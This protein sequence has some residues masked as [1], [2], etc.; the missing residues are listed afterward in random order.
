[1][2]ISGIASPV[3]GKAPA[4]NEGH[5]YNERNGRRNEMTENHLSSGNLN[6][7]IAIDHI[8]QGKV[9]KNPTDTQK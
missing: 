1:M 7:P 4:K 8:A 2:I 9:K 3:H 5:I 6:H